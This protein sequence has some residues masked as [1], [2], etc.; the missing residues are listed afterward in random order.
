M[1]L[2]IR[3]FEFIIDYYSGDFNLF[4]K[5]QNF[6]RNMCEGT[7]IQV[8]VYNAPNDFSRKIHTSEKFKVSNIWKKA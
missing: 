6:E 3:N 5:F 1:K 4:E 2:S 7:S 8:N